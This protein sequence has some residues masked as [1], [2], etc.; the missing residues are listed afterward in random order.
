MP[1]I[2]THIFRGKRFEID[3]DSLVQGWCDTPKEKEKLVLR[4][5]C[6]LTQKRESLEILLH[7]SLHACFPDMPEKEVEVA[8]CDISKFLYRLGY[9]K[10]NE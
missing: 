10:S 6:P 3:I 4:I 7:E 2:K 8:A 1:K 9:R 5:F